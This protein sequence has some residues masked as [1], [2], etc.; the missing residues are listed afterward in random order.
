MLRNSDKGHLK[1]FFLVCFAGTLWSFGALIIRYMV[2][3][4]NYQWQYLFYRGLTIAAILLIYLMVKEGKTFI[5]SFKHSGASE[6]LGA[7]GLLT[8][9][10][11]F[12]WSITMTTVA[13]CLFMLATAP[14]VAAFLGI[15]LL[16][17]DVRPRTWAAMIIAL[18]G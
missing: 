13:N 12:I 16:K 2:E 17:E 1:G 14:F 7:C 6:L 15:V 9:F 4:R 5:T 18:A 10:I 3:A 11:G 8:A